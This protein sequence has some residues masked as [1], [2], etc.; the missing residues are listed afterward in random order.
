MKQALKEIKYYKRKYLLVEVLLILLLFMVLFLS[1]LVNGLGRAVS[2]GIDHMDADYFLL[3]EDAESLITIS[4]INTDMYMKAVNLTNC[5][6]SALNIQRMY[7]NKQGNANKLDVTYFVMEQD[8]FLM[9][10]PYKGNSLQDSDE[11]YTILLNNTYEIEGIKVGDYVE[12]SS[13]GIP[14]KVV[15]FVKDEYYGHTAVGIISYKTY[16]DIRTQLNP[17]YSLSYHTLAIRGGDTQNL[18][19]DGYE[20]IDKNEVI[21]NLPGYAAEQ[22]TIN[23]VLWMLVVVSGAILGV[24]FY[25][26][27]IQKVKQFGVM[28]AMGISMC[29]LTMN[30]ICQIS[31][32]AIV[33][34][35]IGN[36]L[37]FLMSL[38]LPVKMPFYLL[39]FDAL[40]VSVVFILIAIVGSL[41]SAA[42]VAKVD[43]L[44]AIGGNE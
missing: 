29:E 27:T 43:P 2:S 19:F 10:E 44:I 39:P 15:G 11:E 34:V 8:S 18:V 38:A 17:N 33:G 28:K 26:M 9:P 40:Q 13:T 41:L 20:L 7:L 3:K 42:K 31:I 36:L 21:D 12:D 37:V 25:V 4:D 32:L 14:M 23:M 5:E 22:M 16:T 30:L 35:L 6:I 1:G 24:F